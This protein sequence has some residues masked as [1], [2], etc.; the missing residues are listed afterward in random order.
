MTAGAGGASATPAAMRLFVAVAVPEDVRAAVADAA[1]PLR[2]LAAKLDVDVRWTDPAGWH[3]TVAFLGRTE[4]ALVDPLVAALRGVAGDADPFDVRLRPEA[5]RNARSGVLWVEL[6]PCP[7]LAALAG[8]VRA[9]LDRLGVRR[10]PAGQDRAYRPHLTLARARGRASIP[11]SLAAAY[12]GPSLG[13]TVGA[14]ELVRSRLGRVGARYETV[15]TSA[16]RPS[17]GE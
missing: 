12:R 10:D 2:P 8:S 1:A 17:D 3:L 9:A 14:L 5:G 15:A 4:A 6:E 16:F 13:W 11:R 7:P